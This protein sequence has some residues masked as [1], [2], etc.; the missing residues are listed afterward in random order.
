MFIIALSRVSSERKA[1][2]KKKLVSSV[3]FHHL[4]R[5][6]LTFC[7]INIKCR[8]TLKA[9]VIFRLDERRMWRS[10]HFWMSSQ[11]TIGCFSVLTLSTMFTDGGGRVS[12]QMRRHDWSNNMSRL[13]LKISFLQILRWAAKNGTLGYRYNMPDCTHQSLYNVS[14]LSLC[15]SLWNAHTLTHTF[16]TQ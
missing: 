16:L 8:K 6:K 12:A 1:G 4:L 10:S 3:S 15:T 5:T 9:Q 2:G 11:N 13:K 7:W 14:L